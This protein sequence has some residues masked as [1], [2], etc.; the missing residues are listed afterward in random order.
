MSLHFLFNFK[1]QRA[2]FKRIQGSIWIRPHMEQFEHEATKHQ[3]VVNLSHM[4]GRGGGSMCW[5]AQKKDK[6]HQNSWVCFLW[7][8]TE[9]SVS[10]PSLM[11][12]LVPM[13]QGGSMWG[14]VHWRRIFYLGNDFLEGRKV[15][16]A[17]SYPTFH[18][19]YFIQNMVYIRY[20]INAY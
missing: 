17:A 10:Y 6:H 16:K 13:G 3:K 15:F 11:W 8:A 5:A 14:R 9:P 2:M 4:A 1:D 19:K 18:L 20:Y 12:R 7:A